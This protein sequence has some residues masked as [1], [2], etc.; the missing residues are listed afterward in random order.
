MEGGSGSDT[1]HVRPD[2]GNDVIAIYAD[3][4]DDTITYDVGPGTDFASIDG[5]DGHDFL[6]VN[7][8][9]LPFLIRDTAANLIYQFGNGET[10]TITVANVEHITVKDPNGTPVYTWP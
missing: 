10:T 5:G 9:G 4:G 7:H 2:G 1:I 8:N 3:S 6:I